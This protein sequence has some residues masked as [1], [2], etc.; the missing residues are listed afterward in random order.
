[1]LIGTGGDDGRM[2]MRIAVALGIVY[3]VWGSTYLA[4][5]VADRTLPPLLML[6]VRFSLAGG[7]LY[8]WSL[9]RGDVAAARPGRREWRAA[10]IVGG[11]LLFVDTGGVAWAEQRVASGMTALLVAAVPLFT[12]LLDR[13]F[14]GV[15]LSLGALVGIATGLLGVAL[16]VGPSTHIDAVGAAVILG[17]A[18][19]WA[20][21]SVYG[22]VAPLPTAPF[23]SAAMQM[24]CAAAF[25]AV[26]GAA[27]GEVGRVHPVGVSVGSVAAF[28]FLVVFGSIIA[29][30]AYGWLLRSGAPS[31]LVSTYA[32]VNPAVAVLLGWAFAGE[33]VGGRE[34]TA[35]VVIL[36]SVGMLVLARVPRQHEPAEPL[37]ETIGPYLR[38]KEAQEREL[39]LPRLADVRRVAP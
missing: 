26:A 21:G 28:G 17:A 6:A 23:L 31:V 27:T 15:R 38:R 12:A 20:S 5:A 22:R 3:V 18:L 10:A 33:A 14:F 35:G 8:Y 39:S 11:L 16:L 25:L 1:V 29:F 32:Y 37:P 7:L 9:R 4:I 19:A 24:L 36:G 34:L 2:R 13:T 30:T